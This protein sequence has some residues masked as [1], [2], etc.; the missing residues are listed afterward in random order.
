MKQL[1]KKR[2]GAAAVCTALLTTGALAATVTYKTIQVQ[3]SGIHLV[4]DGVPITPKDA[5]GVEVEPFVYNGTTYLP[6]RAVGEA[7]GKQVTWEGSSQ[8]VYIGEVP[9]A[10]EYLTVVCPPYQSSDYNSGKTFSMDG[11][12]YHANSFYLSTPFI[13]DHPHALFNLNGQY[14]ALEVTI[15]HLDRY[16]NEENTIYVYLDGVYSQ[17]ITLKPEEM[18][19]TVTIPLEY[20]LQLKIQKDGYGDVGFANA[21]LIR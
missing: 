1:W 19:K 5:N 11:V 9:G 6:V 4:V 15:G 10:A 3:Y 21:K 12:S 16:A 17:S 20:A 18:A 7:I 8:T 13:G 14:S 2:I